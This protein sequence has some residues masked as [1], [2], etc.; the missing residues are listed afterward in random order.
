MKYQTKITISQIE[1][2]VLQDENVFLYVGL[3]IWLKY[4]LVAD[5]VDN[6]IS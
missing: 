3:F 6:G 5:N 4:Y 1:I 2:Y